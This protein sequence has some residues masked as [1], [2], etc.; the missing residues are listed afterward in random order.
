MRTAEIIASI[1]PTASRRDL[2]VSAHDQSICCDAYRSK[3]RCRLPPLPRDRATHGEHDESSR[4]PNVASVSLRLR[5]TNL[6]NGS[7]WKIAL[8]RSF[9]EPVI[10]GGIQNRLMSI[11]H[12]AR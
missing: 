3:R 1:P 12:V 4:R 7:A 11:R 9:P 8:L 5:E 2:A 6:D 10:R